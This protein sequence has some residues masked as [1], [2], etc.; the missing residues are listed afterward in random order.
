MERLDKI[1]VSQGVGSRKEV[2]KIIR[3]KRV[4]VDSKLVTKPEFKLDAE[5]SEVTLD[6]QTLNTKKHIY[7]ML[8]KPSGFVSATEDNLSRT[9]IELVP[10]E[11]YRRGLFPAG[12]LD[13]DTEGLMII[14]DDG[15]FAHRLT[16]PKN[17][18][19]KT[20]LAE[21]DKTP[22]D[23]DVK[24]FEK[25]IILEDGTSLLPAELEIVS[26]KTARVR[27]REGKFH[28]V[29]K[30]FAAR[31]MRVMYL[32]REKIGGLVLDSNLTKGSCR[33][34]TNTEKEAIF[35]VK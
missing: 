8:N 30:M 18:V 10:D 17:H 34:L 11:L 4:S 21:L 29:K 9:V 6:G 32:R 2:Q 28:Q 24:A 20:Y 15:D 22:T 19:W 12:R 31:S 7:I 35:V 25:G 26:D 14:T 33:E 16:S 23:E 13:K 5:L 27:I 1:L 3:S